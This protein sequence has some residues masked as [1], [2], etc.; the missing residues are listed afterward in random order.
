MQLHCISC[1]V[2][3]RELRAAV[4]SSPHTIQLEFLPMSLH[5]LEAAV[6]RR[7]L[8]EAIGFAAA[9][10]CDAVLL[11][12]GLCGYALEGLTAASCRLVVPRVHDCVGMLFGGEQRLDE[13]L[14]GN[15]GTCFRTAGWLEDLSGLPDAT[16]THGGVR[17]DKYAARYGEDNAEYLFDILGEPMRHYS[18]LAFVQTG[19]AL[20]R[21][22]EREAREEA[23]RRGWSFDSVPGDDSLLRRFVAGDWLEKDFLVV[24]PSRRITATHDERVI[25]SVPA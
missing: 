23:A 3:A 24:E 8:Q 25:D 15:P 17:F 20:D 11:A 16:E 18:R 10:G 22:F 14:L 19:V 12:F 13:Y 4:S 21:R 5:G 2:L 7:R 1:Q 9:T 6:R